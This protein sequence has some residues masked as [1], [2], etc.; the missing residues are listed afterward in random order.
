MS[1]SNALLLNAH[2][3][4]IKAGIS[5][6]AVYQ[7]LGVDPD[8]QKVQQALAQ[9]RM[10]QVPLQQVVEEVRVALMEQLNSGPL[11]LALVARQLGR[12]ERTLRA[13]L[14]DA[15]TNYQQILADTQ[16]ILS[17]RLLANTRIAVEEVGYR[18]G[19]A[20]RSAFYRAFKRW[21]GTT[22]NQYRQRRQMSADNS[23]SRQ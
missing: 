5:I 10:R 7:R 18:V 3:A 8:L 17:K 2:E 20:E 13:Q 9:K 22:P 11:E 21:T 14:Q 4:M 12:S 6:D 15:G 23:Q 19:F 16:K 1:D